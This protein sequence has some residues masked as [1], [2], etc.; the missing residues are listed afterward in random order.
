MKIAIET[1]DR[2]FSELLERRALLGRM[3]VSLLV[4]RYPT[5]SPEELAGKLLVLDGMAMLRVDD[6]LRLQAG[7]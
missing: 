2:L 5:L 1:Q 3:M 4:R 7:I 6:E